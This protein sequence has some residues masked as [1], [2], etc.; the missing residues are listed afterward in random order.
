MQATE[1]S[2]ADLFPATE[3]NA[4]QVSAMARV[5]LEARKAR[6]EAEAVSKRL[7][8][9]LEAAENNLLETMAVAGVKSI[10]VEHDGL[11]VGIS[12]T[13][14][15]YY[16][17]PPG[18]IDDD[19]IVEWLKAKGGGDLIKNTIHHSSFSAFCR[20][21]VDAAGPAELLP[22]VKVAERRGVQV[23]RG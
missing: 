22:A 19:V 16:S 6:E 5:Y 18:A 15:T 14:S 3:S 2:L 1:S 21:L 13:S 10:K 8:A 4:D 7:W 23:R 17:L 20:E 9:A 11:V 12:T